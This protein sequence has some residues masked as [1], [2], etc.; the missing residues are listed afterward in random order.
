M[1][2][3]ELAKRA[4]EQH[5]MVSDY[6]ENQATKEWEAQVEEA[7]AVI[8]KNELMTPEEKQYAIDKYKK[9]TADWINNRNA[10]DANHVAWFVAGPAKY[11]TKKHQK[12]LEKDDAFMRE[13]DYIFDVENYI[14]KPKI[15]NEIKQDIEAKEYEYNGITVIQNTEANRLQLIFDGKPSDETRELLKKN[16]FKWSPKNTAWQR[17]LTTNALHTLEKIKDSLN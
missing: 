5:H 3:E 7:T 16:G 11:N 14:K 4:W 6:E 10:N 1:I 15:R 8:M 13:Y 12:W 17:Q 2:N 9:K